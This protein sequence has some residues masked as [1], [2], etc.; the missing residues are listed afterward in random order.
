MGHTYVKA[1]IIN[2]KTGASKELDFLIDTGATKI[3]I[4]REVAEELELE[5]YG[6][7]NVELADGS[8]IKAIK[9]AGAIEY[10][11]EKDTIPVQSL[12]NGTEPLLGV[13]F[14]EAFNLEVNSK[15]Q[16]V[17]KSRPLKAK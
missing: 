13:L 9:Y 12:G 14:L 11:N 1:K 16:I 10:A 3:V 17:K 7:T 4:P 8:I 2:P 15:E 6:E 5:I